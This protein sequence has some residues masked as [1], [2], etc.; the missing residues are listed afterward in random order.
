MLQPGGWA[1][2]Q[3]ALCSY[4]LW[5][6]VLSKDLAVHP[7][8]SAVRFVRLWSSTA[9]ASAWW[10]QKRTLQPGDQS[11]ALGSLVL[12]QKGC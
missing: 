10:A 2:G 8:P 11:L 9:A 12:A 7:E 4:E 6:E 5:S 3:T 1:C